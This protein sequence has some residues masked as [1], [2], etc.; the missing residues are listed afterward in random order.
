M[1]KENCSKEAKTTKTVR[2]KE[3]ALDAEI[4][5]TS[6]GNVQNH[7]ETRTKGLLLE[8]L[9]AIAAKMRKKKVKTELVL[10]LKHQM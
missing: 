5:I 9:E 3:N 7:Q 6:L 1:M 8:D 4:L 10:W 2:A